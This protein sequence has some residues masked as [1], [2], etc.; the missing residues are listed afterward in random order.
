MANPGSFLDIFNHRAE[1]ADIGTLWNLFKDKLYS[2]FDKYVPTKLIKEG[3]RYHNPC[4]TP[5][6]SLVKAKQSIQ[7]PELFFVYR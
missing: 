5:N 7:F 4:I 3:R 1:Q 6:F 2:L